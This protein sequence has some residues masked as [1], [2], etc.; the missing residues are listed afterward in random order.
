ME[1]QLGQRESHPTLSEVVIES[2]TNG[3]LH[4]PH[5]RNANPLNPSSEETVCVLSLLFL[6][7]FENA[8]VGSRFSVVFF[9]R[10]ELYF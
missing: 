6:F 9:D 8:S 1:Q 10:L 7:V 4:L 3:Y 5:S 2:S